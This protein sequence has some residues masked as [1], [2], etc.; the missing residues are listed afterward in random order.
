MCVCS[1]FSFYY[2]QMRENVEQNVKQKAGNRK[3]KNSA[4][5]VPRTLSA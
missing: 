3:N 2:V 4:Q 5:L 1:S